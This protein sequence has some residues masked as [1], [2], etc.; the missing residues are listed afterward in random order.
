M[1]DLERHD[2]IVF[3]IMLIFLAFTL[4]VFSP[5]TSQALPF[6]EA[7]ALLLASFFQY[8]LRQKHRVIFSSFLC[9]ILFIHGIFT[10]V[11]AITHAL[12]IK[13]TP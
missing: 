9:V 5:P 1:Q 10:L 11:Y 13:S 6:F 4:T 7:S 2:L 3:S 8:I 12:A